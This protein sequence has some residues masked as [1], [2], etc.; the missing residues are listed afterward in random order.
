MEPFRVHTGRAL[1]LGLPDVDT[2][3]IMPARYLK[4]IE[5]TGFGEFLFAD[6]RTE[7]G[8]PLDDPRY[9][10]ATILLAGPNFG[11]GSSREHA[12]W[13]IA[14]AGFRAV[15]AP[16]FAD[17]FRGNCLK[18]GV[19]PVV[20]PE[21]VVE[22]LLEAVRADPGVELTVDLEAR[23]VRGAGVAAAFEIEEDARRRLLEGLD[24]IGIT[25][26]HEAEIAA[27]EEHRPAWMPSLA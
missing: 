15:I 3:Q 18:N 9:A 26:R 12:V 20:L 2:D 13:G 16:S 19:L 22:R 4:R 27:Y 25:L 6:R 14:Q 24:D 10:G 23:E 21:G 7:P 8:F 17:I 5:R 1:P 11:C